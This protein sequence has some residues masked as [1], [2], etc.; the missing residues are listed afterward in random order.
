[1]T[2]KK[3]EVSVLETIDPKRRGFMSKLLAGGA[4]ALALPAISSVALG[5]EPQEEGRGKG[6]GNAGDPE[7]FAARL[8]EQFD[9]DDDGALNKRELAAALKMMMQRRG[10]PMAGRG[11]QGN[12]GFQGK[13]NG[14]FQGKGKG[15]LQG[16]GNGGFQGKGKGGFEGKGKGNQ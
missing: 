16:K 8:I 12:G 15:G 7:A 6:K 3:E 13:G 11:G 5:E 1:M 9:K 4:A 2:K 14:G 10:G